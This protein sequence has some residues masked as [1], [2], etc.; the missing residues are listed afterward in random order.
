MGIIKLPVKKSV[1]R[2]KEKENEKKECPSAGGSSD[3]TSRRSSTGSHPRTTLAATCGQRHGTR[4]LFRAQRTKPDEIDL[5]AERPTS[6]DGARAPARPHEERRLLPPAAQGEVCGSGGR[7][8]H[9]AD[10]KGSA[11]PLGPGAIP[12]D[13][14]E[15]RPV[16]LRRTLEAEPLR[17]LREVLFLLALACSASSHSSSNE[18]DSSPGGKI[19]MCAWR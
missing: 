6:P 1:I 9:S 3:S 12:N 4:S 18:M 7:G 8:R 14:R 15:K 19:T 5:N 13:H 16:T 17:E 11:P 2:N 10:K